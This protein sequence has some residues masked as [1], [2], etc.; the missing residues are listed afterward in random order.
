MKLLFQTVGGQGVREGLD[1]L[2]LGKKHKDQTGH[3]VQIQRLG[4]RKKCSLNLKLPLEPPCK[5]LRNK[6]P[7]D[8]AG[9]WPP[10]PYGPMTLSQ[11]PYPR[12][13]GIL[14]LRASYIMWGLVS[15]LFAWAFSWQFQI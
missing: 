3:I 4:K 6:P 7:H 8:M 14:R 15:K 2:G 11:W 10:D 13:I 9:P 1:L 12:A 5:K